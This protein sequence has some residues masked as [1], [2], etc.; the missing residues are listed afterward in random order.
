M[1]TSLPNRDDEALTSATDVQELI[2]TAV[3]TANGQ[4]ASYESVKK[5]RILP[6]DLSIESGELTPTLKVRRKVVYEKYGDLLDEM[7]RDT[8]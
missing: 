1:S 7:Y 8:R 5:F 2:E 3:E 6:R 4:L